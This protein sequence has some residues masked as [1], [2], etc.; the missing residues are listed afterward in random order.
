MVE[1]EVGM[2]QSEGV[3]WIRGSL[4]RAFFRGHRVISPP[5]PS[6]RDY[7]LW[8]SWSCVL[9]ALG[10]AALPGL[11]H[12]SWWQTV[13]SNWLMSGPL[14]QFWITL[15][16]HPRPR[17]PQQIC[18]GLCYLCIWPTPAPA[19]ILPSLPYRSVSS[20]DSPVNLLH[21]ALLFQC[22]KRT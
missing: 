5:S 8:M 22:F 16:S 4:P 10:R 11:V 13:T 20:E 9:S 6:C 12:L 17:T 19:S 15:Q 14:P 1:R 3:E 18:R 7:Q 21:A 2:S